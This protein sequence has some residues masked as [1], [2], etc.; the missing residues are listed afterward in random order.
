MLASLF[1]YL[2]HQFLTMFNTKNQEPQT[3]VVS[4]KQDDSDPTPSTNEKN[5]E[6]QNE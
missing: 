3:P 2:S 5:I 4:A 1:E 6:S